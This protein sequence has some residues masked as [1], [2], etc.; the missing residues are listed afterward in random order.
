MT[1]NT[2]LVGLSLI[3]VLIMSGCSGK[4]NL[5]GIGQ[6][7]GDCEGVVSKNGVCGSPIDIYKNRDLI[8]SLQNFP[9]DNGEIYSIDTKGV[10]YVSEDDGKT[11]HPVDFTK[12][13]YRKN[14]SS[15]PSN[16]NNTNKFK[17]TNVDNTLY[18]NKDVLGD[19]LVA[20]YKKQGPILQQVSSKNYVIRDYGLIQKIWIAA[21]E[22]KEEDLHSAETIYVV[23][24]KPSWKVGENKPKKV[25]KMKYKQTP[26]S[27][28][29]FEEQPIKISED[30]EKVLVNYNDDK[31]LE[32]VESINSLDS[33]VESDVKS[34]LNKMDKFLNEGK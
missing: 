13:K 30:K 3:I 28:K 16:S 10:V 11:R 20:V 29:V 33:K 5:L 34:N 32:T 23:V 6:D 22:D 14:I 12:K 1:K 31:E 18:K 9:H 2:L 4:T 15:N 19:D 25:V 24:K 8:K 7:S 21:Y 27:E 17:S 26:I